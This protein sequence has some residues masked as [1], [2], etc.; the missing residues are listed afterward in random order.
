MRVDAFAKVNWTLDVVGKRQDGYHYLDT[1]MQCVS[2]HDTLEIERADSIDVRVDSTGVPNGTANLAHRAAEAYFAA[3]GIDKGASIRI[4]KRI[5]SAAGLGGGSTDAA[6]V[7]RALETLYEPL[8]EEKLKKAAVSI[9]ADVTFCLY[10]GLARATGIGEIL[11]IHSAGRVWLLLV[12]PACGVP[13]AEVFSRLTLPLEKHPKT[14]EALEA[15]KSGDLG[16]LSGLLYNAL[17]PVACAHFAP[18]IAQIKSR[19]TERGALGASMTGSGS[20]VFG[21]FENE[22]SALSALPYFED[23]GFAKAVHTL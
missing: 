23:I 21:V 1:I 19:L 6:A 16:A 14:P 8:G 18:E 13:T 2:L 4:T 3:A 10:G 11:E 22:K 5:P 7:L 12:K 15:L 17:E 9:G 20:C